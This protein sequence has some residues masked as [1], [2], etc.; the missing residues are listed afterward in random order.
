MGWW[1]E[2]KCLGAEEITTMGWWCEIKCLGAELSR[3]WLQAV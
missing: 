2:F 1:C 3:R